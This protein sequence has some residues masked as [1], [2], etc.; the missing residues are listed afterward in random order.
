MA[1]LGRFVCVAFPFLLTV[2]SLICIL[3]VALAGVTDKNLDMFDINTQNLSLSTNNLANLAS[4][5][6]RSPEPV[7][8]PVA[9][10]VDITQA[11]NGASTGS[12]SRRRNWVWQIPTRS[13][14]G[15]SAAPL[16]QTPLAPNRSSTMPHQPSTPP[17][18]RLMPHLSPANP[19]SCLANSLLLYMTSR[20]SPSGLRLSIS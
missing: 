16:A 14:S 5:L 19:S 7:P 18:W 8:V 13:I 15:P 10:P 6:K 3:I 12:T 4:L 17:R 2:A 9:A 1:N 11:I 20:S